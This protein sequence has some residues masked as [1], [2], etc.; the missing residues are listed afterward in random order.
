M[1]GTVL[2]ADGVVTNRIALKA[3]LAAAFYRV[4]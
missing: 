2:I 1:A 3:R 4:V